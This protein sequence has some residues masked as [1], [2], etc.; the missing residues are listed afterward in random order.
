MLNKIKHVL[1]N[2]IEIMIITLSSMLLVL[3][4]VLIPVA[5]YN[6]IKLSI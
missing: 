1:Y 6:I 4:I 3:F 5:L 2:I